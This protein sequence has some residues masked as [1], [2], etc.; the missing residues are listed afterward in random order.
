MVWNHSKVVGVQD[1]TPSIFYM[2]LRQEWDSNPRCFQISRRFSTLKQQMHRTDSVISCRLAYF[3][4]VYSI[5]SEELLQP[6]WWSEK[7]EC[8]W[9]EQG[10][11][12]NVEEI[13]INCI[14]SFSF[15]SQSFYWSGTLFLKKSWCCL[16]MF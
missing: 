2:H 7:C 9:W 5:F 1:I 8:E 16:L 4:L 13:D 3:I 11:S 15:L 14:F 12:K 6:A 10:E